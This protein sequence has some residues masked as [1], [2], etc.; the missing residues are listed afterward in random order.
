MGAVRTPMPRRSQGD[1]AGMVPF[2]LQDA[3]SPTSRLDGKWN[4][5]RCRFHTEMVPIRLASAWYRRTESIS[6]WKRHDPVQRFSGGA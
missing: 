4:D 2:L 6:M 3:I 5:P 1:A